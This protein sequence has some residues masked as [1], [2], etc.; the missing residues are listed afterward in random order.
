MGSLT[1]DQ[2]KANYSRHYSKLRP[3]VPQTV[4]AGIQG[5]TW[6]NKDNNISK[7]NGLHCCEIS[8]YMACFCKLMV[9]NWHKILTSCV[10]VVILLGGCMTVKNWWGGYF[11]W[12]RIKFILS[13]PRVRR[14]LFLNVLMF[15]ISFY[16]KWWNLLRLR[17]SRRYPPSQIYHSHRWF[18]WDVF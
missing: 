11:N 1:Q 12:S 10:R 13:T 16:A 15:Q 14:R 5:Q 2:W 7:M 4:L 9:Q 18:P 6:K 8:S 17:W 3:S